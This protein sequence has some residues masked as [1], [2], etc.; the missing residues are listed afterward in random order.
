MRQCNKIDQ[1]INRLNE[2]CRNLGDV[3]AIYKDNSGNIVI[4]GIDLSKYRCA[5]FGLDPAK[6]VVSMGEG[7]DDDIDSI[8]IPAFAI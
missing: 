5:E 6:L 7:K 3:D 4:E 8:T 1:L 2:N